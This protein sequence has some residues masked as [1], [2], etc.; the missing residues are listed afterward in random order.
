MLGYSKKSHWEWLSLPFEI[1]DNR[2]IA[3]KIVDDRGIE[4]LKIMEID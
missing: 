1:G 2:R 3:G 4:G